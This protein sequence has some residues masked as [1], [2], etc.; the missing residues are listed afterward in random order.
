MEVDQRREADDG[1]EGDR[2]EELM[3]ERRSMGRG[4]APPGH[5]PLDARDDSTETQS[6]FK[7]CL[8]TPCE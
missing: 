4:M 7:I 3:E 2:G 6:Q 8:S 5:S 1:M